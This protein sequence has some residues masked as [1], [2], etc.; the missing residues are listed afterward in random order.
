MSGQI[1]SKHDKNA[2]SPHP[3][4]IEYNLLNDLVFIARSSINPKRVPPG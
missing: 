3:V 2:V 4:L 1:A